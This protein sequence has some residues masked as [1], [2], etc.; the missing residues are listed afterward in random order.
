MLEL[1]HDNDF[2]LSTDRY[3]ST[4]NFIGYRK[5]L[6]QTHDSTDR[7][8]YRIFIQ[9]EIYTPADLLETD[10]RRFDRPFAG[11]LGLSNGLT[12]NNDRRLLDFE[13]TM[14][15]TGPPSLGEA[16]QSAFHK[17]VVNGRIATWQEQI[18]TGVYANLYSKYTREWK[19]QPNPFS[20]HF[21]VTPT[22]AFGNKDIYFE[23]QA[24]FYFGRRSSLRATSA[25]QQIGSTEKEV[26]FVARLAYRRIF[27]D[28]LLEGDL[29][30]DASG[31]VLDP[32]QNMF[33]YDFEF[34][35]RLQRHALKFTYNFRTPETRRTFA[36]IYFTISIS[37]I[38]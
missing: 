31:F 7:R 14:G 3:Y 38:F 15:V 1:R 19:W 16:L 29:L 37:R 17:N 8:Q 12:F 4:G 10:Y 21:A 2:L 24:A 9:Q 6:T 34:Y 11:Y 27:H 28:A 26:F 35:T 18:E 22:V 32:H 25:Y 13:F 20:V 5:L 36:H 33:L 23:Q 30:G